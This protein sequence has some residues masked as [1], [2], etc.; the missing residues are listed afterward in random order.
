MRGVLIPGYKELFENDFL[1]YGEV[2]KD[3]SSDTVIMLILSL[4]AELNT[5]EPYL[6]N[7]KRLFDAITFRYSSEQ[8]YS[9]R[10]AILKYKAMAPEYDGTFFGRR[11]LLSMFLKELKRN[12][13][14][15]I[16]EMNPIHEYNFLLDYLI[17]VDEINNNDH[18]LLE[19]AK[20]YNLKIM[21]TMPLI[22]AANIN[23]YE[24]NEA[25]NPAFELFKLL[26]FC[27]YAYDKYKIYL[28]ELIN[29]YGFINISQSLQVFI[30][31]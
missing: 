14:N 13:K 3:T 19:V 25:C 8:I 16:D 18:D 11:Y 28:K 31:L 9:L 12:N 30:K 7:Q 23:Q 21:P 20:R 24:F 22:W 5:E 6:M 26:S 17:T 27:K 1:S 15:N 10:N 29:K 4:N 2:L